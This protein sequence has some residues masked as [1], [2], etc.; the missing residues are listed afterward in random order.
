VF[1]FHRLAP[2]AGLSDPADLDILIQQLSAAAGDGVR[3]EAKKFGQYAVAAVAEFQG[4]QTV[5]QQTVEQDDG[6]FHL[7]GRHFQAG[8]IDN[9]GNGLV[10]TTCQ[11]LSL[12]DG[13]IDGSVEEQAGNQFPGD[14][15]L[16]DKVA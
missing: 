4:F 2:G 6:G 16:L 1:F 13:W 14:P 3:I 12:A 9:R 11:R 8:D 7:I 10:A 15:L 5:V